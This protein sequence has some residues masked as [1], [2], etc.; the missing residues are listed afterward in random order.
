[1]TD[2]IV[3]GGEQELPPP[4]H[5]KQVE[6]YAFCIQGNQ[7]AIQSIVDRDLNGPASGKMH[8]SAFTDKLFLVFANSNILFRAT[9]AAG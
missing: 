1:M 7:N 8:Y 3:R 5:M 9:I 2:Y 4:Y 6:F